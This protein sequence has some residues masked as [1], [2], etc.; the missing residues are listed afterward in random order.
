MLPLIFPLLKNDPAVTAL[1]GA[2]PVRAYRHGE[3]PQGVV[4][5]YVTWSVPGGGPE[6]GFD[7]PLADFSRVQVDCWADGDGNGGTV[8]EIVANAVRTALERGGVCVAFVAD[9]RDPVTKRFR[10]SYQFDFITP[11]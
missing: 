3:A 5:P 7:G 11:R 10:M 6:N 9:G 1:I 2:D 4:A 8:V